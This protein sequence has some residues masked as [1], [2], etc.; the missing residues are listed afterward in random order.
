MYGKNNLQVFLNVIQIN[1]QWLLHIIKH[2]AI[3]VT[4]RVCE[5]FD[6]HLHKLIGNCRAT[7]G[8]YKT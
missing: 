1:F 5:R 2:T 7:C 4:V 3:A 8:W 6:R